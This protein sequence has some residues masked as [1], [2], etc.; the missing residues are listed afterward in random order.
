MTGVENER[1]TRKALS[2]TV[3]RTIM[4]AVAQ[5]CSNLRL[6]GQGRQSQAVTKCIPS[7]TRG[8]ISNHHELMHM[9]GVSLRELVESMPKA[10]DKRQPSRAAGE[11]ATACASVRSRS[12]SPAGPLS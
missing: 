2:Q 7:D 10:K 3:W 1:K 6:G 8:K 4:P 9:C 12:W 11:A 5:G